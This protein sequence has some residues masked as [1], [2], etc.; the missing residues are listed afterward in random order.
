VVVL[1][2]E[3]IGPVMREV[4]EVVAVTQMHAREMATRAVAL[5]KSEAALK[6]GEAEVIID[7]EE[8]TKIHPNGVE[9]ENAMEDAGMTVGRTIGVE[10]GNKRCQT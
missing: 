9:I 7:M 6:G 2:K 4:A 3:V 1:T 5:L 10:A 8:G